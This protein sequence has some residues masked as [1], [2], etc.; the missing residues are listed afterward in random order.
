MRNI[1]KRGKRR[2]CF[3]L[4]SADVP[5]MQFMLPVFIHNWLPRPE[6]NRLIIVLNLSISKLLPPRLTHNKI[7]HHSFYNFNA[8]F[9]FE[10]VFCFCF[11]VFWQIKGRLRI[12]GNWWQRDVH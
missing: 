4:T 2:L 6:Q 10:F 8:A 3:I 11:F 9:G 12:K 5:W 1:K 7:A